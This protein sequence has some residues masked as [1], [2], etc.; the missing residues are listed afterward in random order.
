MI[1]FHGSWLAVWSGI[2]AAS[3]FTQDM[4]TGRL[5]N[6][7]SALDK[8]VQPPP[9]EPPLHIY[10]AASFPCAVAGRGDLTVVLMLAGCIL[11]ETLSYL[12]QFVSSWGYR[13]MAG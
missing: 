2:F 5:A 8:L 10:W 1:K 12:E 9:L 4:K 13:R 7:L 6:A 3:L 11:P